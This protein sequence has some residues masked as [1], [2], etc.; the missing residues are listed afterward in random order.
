MSMMSILS[1]MDEANCGL[2]QPRYAIFTRL[3]DAESAHAETQLVG[4][5]RGQ[6]RVLLGDLSGLEQAVE[7][8]I[9]GLHALRGAG[10]HGALQLLDGTLLQQLSHPRRTQQDL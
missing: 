7:R 2:R 4:A 1:V 6:Q 5:V 3:D 10:R 8:L 9:E